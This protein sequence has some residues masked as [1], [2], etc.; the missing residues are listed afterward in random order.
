MM[1]H[2]YFPGAV[3]KDY[4]TAIRADTSR[5]RTSCFVDMERFWYFDV[6]FLCQKCG[7]EFCWSAKTQQIWFERF[8]LWTQA[9]PK[10]CPECR[11]K[12]NRLNRAKDDYAK[13]VRDIDIKSRK[14]D[15]KLKHQVIETIGRIEE[16]SEEP[17]TRGYIE[18]RDLLER[19]IEKRRT[20]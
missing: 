5:H 7:R 14:I 4:N 1:P 16:L 6:W 8:G 13:L 18:L 9:Y 11:R 2:Y 20:E 10:L 3:R 12:R 19:Q 15:V 17:L